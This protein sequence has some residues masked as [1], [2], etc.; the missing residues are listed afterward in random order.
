MSHP[1]FPD[2]SSKVGCPEADVL[3]RLKLIELLL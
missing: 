1:I 2:K 3:F